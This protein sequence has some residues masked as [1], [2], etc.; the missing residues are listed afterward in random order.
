M[1]R[2]AEIRR[3]NAALITAVE[4]IGIL[5]RIPTRMTKSA[6]KVATP[7]NYDETV[8]V[9]H[10]S[11]NQALDSL[12]SLESKGIPNDIASEL[13]RK[14]QHSPFD[15]E[16]AIA[17]G[18]LEARELFNILVY[19]LDQLM[20]DPHRIPVGKTNVL[21][22]VDGSR[23]SYVAL[24]IAAHVHQHGVCVVGALSYSH[25]DTYMGSHLTY[26]LSRRLKE[27]YKLDEKSFNIVPIMSDSVKEIV[28]H[29]QELVSNYKCGIIAMGV[30][31]SSAN[32][33]ILALAVMYAAWNLPHLILLAKSVARV[34]D[35]ESVQSPRKYM[36]CVKNAADLDIVFSSTRC[37]VNPHDTLVFAV[38]V[39][40]SDP[41]G[42]ERDTRFG[43]GARFDKWASSRSV[44][45]ELQPDRLGWNIEA[46][47][48]LEERMKFLLEKSQI[49]GSVVV[50]TVDPTKTVAQLICDMAFQQ[51]CDVLV[52]RRG[53]NQEV[54]RECLRRS[55]CNVL[56]AP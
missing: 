30:D 48:K 12:A 42:D 38:V 10:T 45:D 28:E 19:I 22:I 46:N 52:L 9:L 11:F 24:D 53:V 26:D 41:I 7:T 18:G 34:C 20:E 36:I 17:M 4:A 15:Y 55:H 50:A 43:F 33:D 39:E 23:P 32:E 21:T 25:T 40:S 35:F 16:G 13:Y 27:Q 54:S 14:L 5:L 1:S 6:Y 37:F 51:E 47:Q 2:L 49:P 29:V 3:P 8:T 31:T 56:L 44:T